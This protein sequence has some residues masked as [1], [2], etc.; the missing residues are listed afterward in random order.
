MIKVCFSDVSF[1][2]GAIIE[3]AQEKRYFKKQ[4]CAKARDV[5]VLKWA[6]IGFLLTISYKSVLLSKLLNIEYEKGFDSIDDVLRSKKPVVLDV[7]TGMVNLMK[8]DPR[9]NVKEIGKMIKPFKSEKG[10]PPTWVIRGY[11]QLQ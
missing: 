4:P 9:E 5:V 1:S 7:A 3:E 2:L 8:S 6:M 10:A 11:S